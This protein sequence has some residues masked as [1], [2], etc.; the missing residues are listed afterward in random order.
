MTR[1]SGIASL[2]RI[3]G[4]SRAA[5]YDGLQVTAKARETFRTSF[6][7]GHSCKVCPRIDVPVDLSGPE[8]D[9]RA[10]ALRRLHYQRVSLA[11]AQKRRDSRVVTPEA[12]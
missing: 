3:G 6:L 7:D 12:A 5:Q 11:A 10:E 2:A 8:R 4:L 1:A 9:R